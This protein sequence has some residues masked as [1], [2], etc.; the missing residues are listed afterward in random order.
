MTSLRKPTDETLLIINDSKKDSDLFYASHFL[1]GDPLIYIEHGGRKFLLVS[2]LE[3]GRAEKEADVDEV[4][5]T[6]ELEAKLRGQGK[7]ARLTSIADLFLQSQGGAQK[8]AVPASMPFGLARQL[9]ELGYELECREDPV[10]PERWFKT[11]EEI[12]HIAGSQ[13][14]GEAAM[15]LVIETLR[16]S[17]IRDD[18]LYHDGEVL[19]SEGLRKMA[20][21]LLLDKSCQA[22]DIIIA[23]GDQC[24]DPHNRGTG[25]I[26][27]NQTIIIDIFPQSEETRYW[28]DMTRTVVRGKASDEARKLYQDVFDAQDGAIKQLRDGACGKEIHQGI[29]KLFEARGNKTEERN[30]SKVG[31]FHGTGH[32]VGLDI[33]ENPRLGKVGHE[34]KTGHVIT[35]EPGLYY[36]GVGG[37]RIEDLLVVTEDGHHNL[38]SFPKGPETFEI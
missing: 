10:L 34:L 38:T 14:A 19:T 3:Y 35:I 28:G 13:K 8:I 4:V 16:S 33:H 25:P 26:P 11:P 22:E 24:C 30:G 7:A 37:V 23:A 2:D 9:R 20:Q 15:G 18:L 17:E 1:V 36:P 27:A 31:F 6:A 32:G 21:K 5:G 12:E 29:V